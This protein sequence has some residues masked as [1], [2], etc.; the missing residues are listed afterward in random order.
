MSDDK[1]AALVADWQNYP[2]QGYAEV[3]ERSGTDGHFNCPLISH[4]EDGLWVGGCINNVT[5]DAD[6]DTV[7]SLFSRARYVLGPDATRHEFTMSDSLCVPP[8]SQLHHIADIVVEALDR[9]DKVLVHCQ[10]GLNRS[11]L[12][13]ALALIKRGR[14]PADA[15]TLLR[16]RRSPAVLCNGAFESWLLTLEATDTDPADPKD[17]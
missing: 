5:L 7:V 14:T 15:I 10:A 8:A 13:A 17:S 6:F 12:I 16:D 4:I 11:N 3:A 9:G 1:A 2:I